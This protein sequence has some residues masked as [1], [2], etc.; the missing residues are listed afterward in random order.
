MYYIGTTILGMTE[1]EF[2]KSFPRKLFVLLDRHNKANSVE[3]AKPKN[4]EK[5]TMQDLINLK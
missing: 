4:V 3:E 5:M 2:W 1:V